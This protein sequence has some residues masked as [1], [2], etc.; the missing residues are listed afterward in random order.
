MAGVLRSA[1][2]VANTNAAAADRC[3][4]LAIACPTASRRASRYAAANSG[5]FSQRYKVVSPTPARCAAL[6]MVAVASKQATAFS[7]LALRVGLTL[8]FSAMRS[9]LLASLRPHRHTTRR[10]IPRLL[11]ML[12]VYAFEQ[13]C[14]P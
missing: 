4:N 14:L 2:V 6:V 11:I 7:C 8:P 12:L 9:Q 1:I 5:S 13:P 3:C 10:I